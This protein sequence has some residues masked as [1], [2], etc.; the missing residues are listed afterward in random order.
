[1]EGT[2][3]NKKK[4]DRLELETIINEYKNQL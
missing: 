1:L 2:R 4:W 3:H